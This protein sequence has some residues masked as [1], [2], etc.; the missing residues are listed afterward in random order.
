MW[1]YLQIHSLYKLRSVSTETS[2]SSAKASAKYPNKNSSNRK[3]A[4][5]Q[6]TMGRGK[7]RKA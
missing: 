7:R 2:L 5:A 4:S 1:H 3:L 6:G